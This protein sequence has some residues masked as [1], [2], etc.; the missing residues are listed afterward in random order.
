MDEVQ[1]FRPL[2]F[3][4]EGVVKSP[5]R[6]PISLSLRVRMDAVGTSFLLRTWPKRILSPVMMYPRC[7]GPVVN[8]WANAA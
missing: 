6:L 8:A 1:V 7:I 4:L 3:N 5:T 2:A